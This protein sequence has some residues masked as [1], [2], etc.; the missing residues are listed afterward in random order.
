MNF[1]KEPEYPR[2]NSKANAMNQTDTP[3]LFASCARG[4]KRCVLPLLSESDEPAEYT[5][6]LYFADFDN[7]QAGKR[8]FDIKL[9]GKLVLDSFD[10]TRQAGHGTALVRQ[11]QGI[12]VKDSLVIELLPQ[13]KNLSSKNSLPVLCGVEVM[14]ERKTKN[15]AA[16]VN[17]RQ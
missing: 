8:I 6:K 3:W 14:Q 1:L 12:A 9:Q 16:A 15:I 13:N 5:V 17:A 10:I 2:E 4:L 7:E 11:F